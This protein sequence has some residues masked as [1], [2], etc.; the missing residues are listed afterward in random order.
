VGARLSP[1]L[2]LNNN[3]LTVQLVH[4]DRL[5]LERDI[6]AVHDNFQL[7]TEADGDAHAA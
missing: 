7:V 1:T 5:Q 2:D 6:A 4:V 3:P